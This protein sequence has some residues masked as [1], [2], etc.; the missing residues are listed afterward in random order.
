M[1]ANATGP[2]LFT[3]FNIALWVTAWSHCDQRGRRAEGR[4]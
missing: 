4:R 1:S 3:H 2:Q